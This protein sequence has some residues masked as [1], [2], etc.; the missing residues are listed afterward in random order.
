MIQT[1]CVRRH[2]RELSAR[3]AN[4]VPQ[5]ILAISELAES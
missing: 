2:P 1:A 4:T 3:R 5:A